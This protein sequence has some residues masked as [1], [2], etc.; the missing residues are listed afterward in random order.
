IDCFL[1]SQ[2]L[3]GDT[4]TV[5]IEIHS[6]SNHAPVTFTHSGVVGLEMSK[7]WKL[8]VSLL[9]KPELQLIIKCNDQGEA[10]AKLLWDTLKA[11]VR[12]KLISYATN[13][14]KVKQ[15]KMKE[16]ELEIQTEE[17]ALKQNFS[18]DD[19]LS[20]QFLKY[21]YNKLVSQSIEFAL[22]C[23]HQSYFEEGER[24]SKLLAYRLQKLSTCNTIHMIKD[25]VGNFTVT[26]KDISIA[27]RQFYHRLYE[28]EKVGSILEITD[29]L[30]GINLPHLD[31]IDRDLIFI[32]FIS[33]IKAIFSAPQARVF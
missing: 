21:E 8:N 23:V 17:F 30:V 27:Y 3:V 19:F 33:W 9:Q 16:L 28:S 29:Y 10:D 4:F 12:G 25:N 22:F 7:R 31:Q 11:V 26:N 1:I 20:L 32:Y 13:H 6:I 18:L 24:A 15:E 5:D 2:T 14:K